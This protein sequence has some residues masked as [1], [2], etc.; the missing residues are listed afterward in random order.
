MSLTVVTTHTKTLLVPD[1]GTEDKVYGQDYVSA[2]SHS[3][4]VAGTASPAQMLGLT[5]GHIY[6]GDGSNLPA[7]VAVS[8]DLT[9]ASTGAYTIANGAVTYAKMQNISATSRILG[10]ATAGAGSTEELTA[11]QVISIL[12]LATV[13]TSGSAADL[14]TGTLPD[15]RL[16]N[17]AV[18]PAA[19]T[20]ANITVDAHGRIT[21]AAN[22]SASATIV[23]VTK[24]AN[25]TMVAG[26]HILCDTTAGGFTLT[27]PASPSA[28]DSV[29]FK[30]GL[31]ASPSLPVTLGRNS[32]KIMN[33]AEN[34]T[35]NTPNLEVTYVFNSTWGWVF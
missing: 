4:A 30:S 19:Y 28:N 11:A 24:T 3:S 6:V 17:T 5:T 33:V 15:A 1:T 8:G 18:T 10:R 29:T 16:S 31:A 32:Q 35:V 25:Y 7:D 13:A 9:L 27:F 26:D 23:W 21:A 14:G 34:Q 12:G 2:S 20:S 22:G